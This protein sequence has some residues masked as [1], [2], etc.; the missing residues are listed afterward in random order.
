MNGLNNESTNNLWSPFSIARQAYLHVTNTEQ[1][2]VTKEKL[3]PLDA[4]SARAIK[5]WKR[6]ANKEINNNDN[7]FWREL[8]VTF[9]TNFTGLIASLLDIFLDEKSQ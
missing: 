4:R 9:L 6:Y 8:F 3:N 5:A 1:D 7:S 2:L